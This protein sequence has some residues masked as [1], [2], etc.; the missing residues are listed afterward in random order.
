M[1]RKVYWP[2]RQIQVFEH[3]A[4][5][6]DGVDE[7]AHLLSAEGP[8]FDTGGTWRAF[9]LAMCGCVCVCVCDKPARRFVE[10]AVSNVGSDSPADTRSKL[11][12][13]LALNRAIGRVPYPDEGVRS[14]LL[15][16]S[17][18]APALTV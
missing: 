4:R 7:L 16:R 3:R 9:A 12:S 1:F 13:A 18:P 6:K 11:L 15:G 10:D 8:A 14:R 2:M 5:K 17:I